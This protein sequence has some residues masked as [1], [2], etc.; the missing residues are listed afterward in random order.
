MHVDDVRPSHERKNASVLEWIDTDRATQELPCREIG[1]T[2]A[3]LRLVRNLG[4][5]RG[6][7]THLV[8][9]RTEGVDDGV[10]VLFDTPRYGGWKRCSDENPKGTLHPRWSLHRARE[11][12]LKGNLLD[13]AQT[14]ETMDIGDERPDFR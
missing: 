9:L 11:A 8:P 3:F 6:E 1:C 5:T 2:G 7:D 14:L 13:P 4:V 10:G 12:V